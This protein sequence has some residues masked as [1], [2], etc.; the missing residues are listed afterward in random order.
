[1]SPTLEAIIGTLLDIASKLTLENFHN[2][3]KDE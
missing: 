2:L 1:M 3:L